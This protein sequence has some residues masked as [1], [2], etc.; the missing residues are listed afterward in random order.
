MD[1]NTQ[2]NI[3]VSDV[4]STFTYLDDAVCGT[5]YEGMSLQAITDSLTK[6]MEAGEFD[7]SRYD[8]VRRCIQYISDA[9]D[10]NPSWGQAVLMDT[11]SSTT[12]STEAWTDDPI[13][14]ATFQMENGDYYVAFRGTGD[15]RWTDNAMGMTL[16]STDMQNAAADYF[17][18]MAERYGFTDDMNIYVA[19]HS[20]GGNEAQYVYM[21]EYGDLIDA[22]YS[23]DGQGFSEKAIEEFKKRWGDDYEKRLQEMYSICGENDPV[24]RLGIRIIPDGNTYYVDCIDTGLLPWHD[25]KYMSGYEDEKGVWHYDGLH[26]F[27]DENGNI[28]NG[29]PGYGAELGEGIS[30][31]LMSLPEDKRKPVA[32]SVMHF[33]DMLTGKCLGYEDEKI[34]WYMFIGYGLPLLEKELFLTPEGHRA[35]LQI[36]GTVAESFYK[37]HGV[38]GCIIA[39]LITAFVLATFPVLV[40]KA[41]VA[42]VGFVVLLNI[43]SMA[44]RLF[45]AAVDF[46][47]KFIDGLGDVGQAFKAVFNYLV[48]FL[49]KVVGAVAGFIKSLDPDVRYANDNPH[50]IVNTTKLREY[51]DDLH[52]INQTIKNID[53]QMDSLYSK[54]GLLDIW[55]LLQADILTSYNK[56]IEK[57]EAYCRDTAARFEAAD[58]SIRQQW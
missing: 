21:S 50:I 15:G 9:V 5:Q 7:D 3:E 28:I 58:N 44:I 45:D 17:K 37:E 55:N 29:T 38:G 46:L 8:D 52:S 49:G 56:H 40:F 33:I 6:R 41:I 19:G 36:I 48:D 39:G 4:F 24:H 12:N 35:L 51:A 47:G 11:S 25:I 32:V 16:P 14:G 23:F 20:K 53:S 43:A 30:N 42:V 27:T 22:C 57:A 54:V 31:A 1:N 18:E 10:Q 34:D 26:W 13:Q 2:G